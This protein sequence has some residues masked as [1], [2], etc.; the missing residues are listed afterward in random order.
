MPANEPYEGESQEQFQAR[1]AEQRRQRQKSERVSRALEGFRPRPYPEWKQTYQ[2]AEAIEDSGRGI[3]FEPEGTLPEPN[4]PNMVRAMA[5]LPPVPGAR[6]RGRLEVPPEEPT[7]EQRGQLREW[8]QKVLSIQRALMEQ[9]RSKKE[10]EEEAKK[11]VEQ[12]HWAQREG[13]PTNEL[14]EMYQ[15]RIRK[16]RGS[17]NRHWGERYGQE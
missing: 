11:I 12:E 7:D 8:K 17:E 13:R 2:L 1:Q 16:G 3:N 15:E 4:D 10:A 5:G 9:G 14:P 6:P